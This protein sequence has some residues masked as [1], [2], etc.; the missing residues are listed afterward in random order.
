MAD[1]CCMIKRK[2]VK[3]N[4]NK[5]NPSYSIKILVS[6]I[7]IFIFSGATMKNTRESNGKNPEQHALNGRI[8]ILNIKHF[9]GRKTFTPD[10]KMAM[11]AEQ[12]AIKYLKM[13]EPKI[14]NSYGMY[15]KQAVGYVSNGHKTIRVN[16]IFN[17][18][19]RFTE[20]MLLNDYIVIEDGGD[21][22]FQ[23]EIDMKTGKVISFSVNGQA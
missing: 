5:I 15:C 10:I 8:Y 11:S 12:I 1:C 18:G 21:S 14:F 3:M 9:N 16:Y 7:A 23:M 2:R 6:I 20:K 22:V 17:P 19:S 4:K 13:K